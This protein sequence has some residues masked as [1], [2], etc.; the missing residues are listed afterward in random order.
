LGVEQHQQAVAGATRECEVN[1]AGQ[2]LT[3]SAV[4]D[5]VGYFALDDFDESVAELLDALCV[6]GSGRGAGSD[7]SRE[8]DDRRDVKGAGANA[9]FLAS[10]VQEGN[11]RY[12]ATEQEG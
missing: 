2:P 12:V 8:T 9:A 6:V 1:M 11:A 10:A 3:I 4:E 7:R 5:G